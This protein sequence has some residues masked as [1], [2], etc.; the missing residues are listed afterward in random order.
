MTYSLG[1]LG[2]LHCSLQALSHMQED[3]PGFFLST[4]YL[5]VMQRGLGEHLLVL[6][7]VVEAGW[8]IQW[9]KL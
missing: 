2:S 5:S 3:H 7:H 6:L 8:S 4:C 9:D 1:K